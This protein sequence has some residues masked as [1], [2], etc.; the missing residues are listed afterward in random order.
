MMLRKR[1]FT[2]VELLVVIAI[3]GILV[4]LLLPA[5]QSAREAA[6]RMQCS[7]NLKQQA[8]A[9]LNYESSYKKFPAM[10]SGTGQAHPCGG[11]TTNGVGRMGGQ[12]VCMSGWYSILP[13]IEQTAYYNQLQTLNREPWTN[14]VFP[15]GSGVRPYLQRLS[16]LEC[17][18]D[19]GEAEPT[20]ASRNRGL[21]SYAFCSGDNYAMSQ[22]LNGGEERADCNR[23]LIKAPI[24]NRGMFG[25]LDFSPMG[26]CADGTSNTICVGER[27]RPSAVNSKGMALLIAA[28]PASYAPLSCRAQFDGRQYTNAGLIFTSDTAPGYRHMAGNAFFAGLSTIL[29]PNSAVCMVGNGSVSPH[30]FGGIWSAGSEHTGGAQV[31]FVDGSV[32]FISDAIDTGNLGAIAPAATSGGLSPYGVWGALGTKASGEVAQLPE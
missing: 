18:S 2:L 24:R 9:V 26:A 13:Y 4:G 16:F 5:V 32:H 12:R 1:G 27:Q 23:S 10:Q 30:W 15:I 11:G 3:I 19:A 21:T 20:N 29:G 8:L 17:P 25:R 6:R 22:T 28:D 7:N 14:Q 31:A